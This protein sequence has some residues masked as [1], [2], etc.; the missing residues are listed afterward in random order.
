MTSPRATAQPGAHD[1]CP[2][3]RHEASVRLR[4][5]CEAQ[6]LGEEKVPAMGENKV[7]TVEV[8]IDEND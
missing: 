3:A 7:W 4:T 6:Q 5:V 8:L 1:L 2:L